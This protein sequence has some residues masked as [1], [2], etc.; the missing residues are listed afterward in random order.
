[1]RNITP[2]CACVCVCVWEQHEVVISYACAACMEA[3]GWRGQTMLSTGYWEWRVQQDTL[4]TSRM[5][6]VVSLSPCLGIQLLR[7]HMKFIMWSRELVWMKYCIADN[8]CGTHFFSNVYFHDS[9]G[10]YEFKNQHS[11]H[12]VCHFDWATK[13]TLIKHLTHPAP[14]RGSIQSVVVC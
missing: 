10:G 5:I 1:M 2:A 8:F 6:L 14:L 7:I 13:Q 4:T 12:M 3:C 9:T 11:P